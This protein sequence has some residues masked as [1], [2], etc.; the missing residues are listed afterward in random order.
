MIKR[1]L[2]IELFIWTK[3]SELLT[4]LHVLKKRK[5]Q[6]KLF[7]FSLSQILNLQLIFQI[8]SILAVG[9]KVK[10]LGDI[11]K[12]LNNKQTKF[13]RSNTQL[14]TKKISKIFMI[15]VEIRENKE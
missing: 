9:S 6:K 3:T 7:K 11:T 10:L 15:F 14:L 1:N 4:T 2:Q 13:R 8:R 12:H 5:W